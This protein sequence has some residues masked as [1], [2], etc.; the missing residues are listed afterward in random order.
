LPTKNN[1]VRRGIIPQESQLCIGGCWEI[2]TTNHL[3]SKCNYFKSIWHLVLNRIGI[4]TVEVYGILD[5]FVQF[6]HL[7]DN[8]RRQRSI[9]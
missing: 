4:S 9:L 3:F 1:V 5:H 7:S 6:S 8:T 2:G